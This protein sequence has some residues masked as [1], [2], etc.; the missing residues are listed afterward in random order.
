MHAIYNPILFFM[1]L[2]IFTLLFSLV[3]KIHVMS[4]LFFQYE[5]QSW[6]N[7]FF[8][9]KKLKILFFKVN[10]LSS[11]HFDNLVSVSKEVSNIILLI[12]IIDT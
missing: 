3:L 8:V 1:K 4:Y 5:I 10:F 11:S 6:K 9:L 7:W 12:L 2:F